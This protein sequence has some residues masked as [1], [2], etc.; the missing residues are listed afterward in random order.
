MRAK[1]T[2]FHIKVISDNVCLYVSDPPLDQIS[3]TDYLKCYLGKA[4]LE[5]AIDLY[6][7][8]YPGGKYDTFAVS[9]H[10]YYLDP[11]A[12]ESSVPT[13]DL[14]EKRYGTDRIG[15]KEA[16]MK[17]MGATEGFS[18]KLG[19]KIGRTRDSHRV[20]QFAK[21]KGNEIE[22]SVVNS[23]MKSYFEESGDITDT[24]TLVNAAVR[25]GLDEGQLRSWLE[26]GAGI[27]IVDRESEEAYQMGLKGVPHFIMQGNHHL[28]GAQ[29]VE[30]F[31]EQFIAIKEGELENSTTGEICS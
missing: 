4:R 3:A 25:G 18:F 1:M 5:R 29:D 15:S 21:L 17:Q 9:W 16:R 6:K 26:T 10:P 30:S 7:K 19:G 13:R 12:P 11:A 20:V 8:T 27:D 22:N 31:L 23:I 2:N 14:V 24:D 28:D